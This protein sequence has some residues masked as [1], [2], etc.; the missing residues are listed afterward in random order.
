MI[1]K[2]SDVRRPAGDA[3]FLRSI[4]VAHAGPDGDGP[5]RQPSI[6]C[7]DA[8]GAVQDS[9]DAH[10]VATD[11]IEDEVAPVWQQ[12]HAVAELGPCRTD[13][14]LRGEPVAI[15]CKLVHEGPRASRTVPRN[16]RGDSRQV[17]SLGPH[18]SSGSGTCPACGGAVRN[19]GRGA[20]CRARGSPVADGRPGCQSMRERLRK[21]RRISYPSPQGGVYAC[22]GLDRCAQT[23][24]TFARRRLPNLCAWALPGTPNDGCA[25]MN[26]AATSACLDELAAAEACAAEVEALSGMSAKPDDCWRTANVAAR[27]RAQHVRPDGA[28]R[29]QEP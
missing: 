18:P 8:T 7:P 5:L 9:R 15:G 3:L 21:T 1:V 13:A 17:D 20:R 11:T 16:D 12:S 6:G 28:G 14:G 22:T 29:A 27:T 2:K 19:D 26:A 10:D 25:G 24:E 23:A 4:M